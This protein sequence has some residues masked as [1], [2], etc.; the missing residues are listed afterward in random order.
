MRTISS[1]KLHPQRARNR[2]QGCVKSSSKALNSFSSQPIKIWHEHDE[3]CWPAYEIMWSRRNLENIVTLIHS[4]LKWKPRTI[5][6]KIL[7]ESFVARFPANRFARAHADYWCI[8]VECAWPFGVG[9][10]K[11]ILWASHFV[12]V[13]GG[14]LPF[15]KR[16]VWYGFFTHRKTVAEKSFY[17]DKTTIKICRDKIITVAVAQWV[18][19][20]SSG[21]RMVQ[22]KGSSPGGDIY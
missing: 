19:H 20:W 8:S 17:V 15:W 22:A 12:L 21:H 1:T 2:V 14:A 7:H 4:H 9:Y 11:S 16:L 13:G 18:R 10:T 6:Y 3:K 5:T